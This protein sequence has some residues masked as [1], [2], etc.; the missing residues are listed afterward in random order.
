VIDADYVRRRVELAYATTVYGAQGDTVT[1]AHLTVGEHTGAASAYVGMTRGR[2]QNTAHLVADDLD[3]ARRLWVE[4]FSR[5]R[6]DLG[7]AHA[8]R[9]AAQEAG[10]YATP[11]PSTED[12]RRYV[13]RKRRTGVARPTPGAARGAPPVPAPVPDR[14][15]PSS[16]G[17]GF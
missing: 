11:R 14:E 13:P 17:V 12:P 10:K 4:V 1:E 9:L 2:R 8:A 5:D 16:P 7:P 15:H 3:Q 6:A